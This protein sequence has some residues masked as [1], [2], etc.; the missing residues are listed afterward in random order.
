MKLA[1]AVLKNDRNLLLAAGVFMLGLCVS[2]AILEGPQSEEDGGIDSYSA[3]S[4]GVKAA[5]LLLERLGYGVERWTSRPAALPSPGSGTVLVMAEPFP[6]ADAEDKRGLEQF[7]QS[8]GRIVITGWAAGILLP[9]GQTAGSDLPSVAW[10]NCGP[11]EVSALTRGGEISI[12]NRGHWTSESADV[13]T[14]YRCGKDAVVVSYPVARGEVIWWASPTP[15]S[16]AGL[17]EKGNLQLFL[18]SIGGPGTRVLWDE[19]F[20]GGRDSVWSYV[21]DTSIKWLFVQLALVGCLV[22]FTHSRRSGPLRALPQVSRL[23]PLEFVETLGSLYGGARAANVAVQIAYDRFQLLVRKR[24]GERQEMKPAGVALALRERLG[25][26]SE[27][28]QHDLE[29]ASASAYDHTL[30]PAQALLIT[31]RLRE[32]L[33]ALHLVPG[34]PNLEEETN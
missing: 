11:V 4:S 6:L 26:E 19:Y 9:R 7:L 18:S 33:A 21:A 5:Y 29:E 13:V 27:T 8:G 14:H 1:Q 10:S 16:N 24:L 15:M 32:H 12:S 3:K 20:H 25:Y 22:L 28:L 31:Q 23:T 30:E 2:L 34:D 17:R